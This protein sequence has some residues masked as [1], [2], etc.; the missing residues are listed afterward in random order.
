MKD[1]EKALAVLSETGKLREKAQ[2]ALIADELNPEAD[3][4][5]SYYMLQQVIKIEKIIAKHFGIEKEVEEIHNE[6]FR[7]YIDKKSAARKA[8]REI[9]KKRREG[10]E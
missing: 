10:V 4:H 6:A 3:V 5:E 9:K 1:A 2:D 8:L 7:R